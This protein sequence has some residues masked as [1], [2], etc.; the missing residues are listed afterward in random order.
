MAPPRVLPLHSRYVH[1]VGCL[2]SV[3]DENCEFFG[4]DVCDEYGEFFSD[5]LSGR[6][7]LTQDLYIPCSGRSDRSELWSCGG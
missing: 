3:S 2:R 1:V 4:D 6:S 5:G 7:S